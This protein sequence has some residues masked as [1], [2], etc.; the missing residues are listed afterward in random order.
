MYVHNL[1]VYTG[2]I[3]RL[4]ISCLRPV[5][6]WIN[7]PGTILG[8]DWS[9]VIVAVGKNVTSHKVGDHAAGFV[10]GGLYKDWGA[11]AEYICTPAE[12]SWVIP[13]G[14]LSF[15]EAATLGCA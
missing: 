6:R 4:T 14:T 10:H 9:G 15:E 2:D 8:V 11:Y 3:A 13:E 7:N 12:L 1:F 5:V